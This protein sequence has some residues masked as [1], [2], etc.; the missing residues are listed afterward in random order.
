[1]KCFTGSQCTTHYGFR[2][3]NLGLMLHGEPGTGKTS[4]IKAICNYL[5]R[6]AVIVDMSK[7]KKASDFEDLFNTYVY[8]NYVY[9]FEEFDCVQVKIISLTFVK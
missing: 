5:K 8:V 7:I 3:Y 6:D 9:I 1:M 2:S 4:V